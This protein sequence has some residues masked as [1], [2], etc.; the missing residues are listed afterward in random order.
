M[1]R[2]RNYHKAKA[3]RASE[4]GRAMAKARWAKHSADLAAN[5][6]P[7]SNA[8][9]VAQF[10]QARK[11]KIAFVH[12]I[13]N[14][15]TENVDTWIMRH[16]VKGRCDHFDLFKNGEFVTTGGQKRCRKEMTP[17]HYHILRYD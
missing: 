5:P 15:S 2:F 8:N 16:S 10:L 11:G 6:P 3:E 12:D 13:A 7:L 14:A 1:P 9:R 17:P 4:R